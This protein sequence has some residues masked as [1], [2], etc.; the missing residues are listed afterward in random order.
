MKGPPMAEP[1]RPVLASPFIV[2]PEPPLTVGVEEEYMLVD[3]ETRDL[4][5]EPAQGLW[6][7]LEE[8]LPG[9]VSPEFLK[10][11][12]E[13]GTRVHDRIDGAAAELKALRREVVDA[14]E[15]EGHGMIAAST[16]PF[17]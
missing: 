17:A 3:P 14:A 13:V 9:Q 12:V 15:A 10:A 7:R 11:Q 16:H 2:A 5:A 4:V 6:T 8:R 1:D